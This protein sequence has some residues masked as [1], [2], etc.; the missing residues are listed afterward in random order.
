LK[1]VL[2]PIAMAAFVSVS[3]AQSA[4]A[5]PL[6]HPFTFVGVAGDCGPTPGSPIVGADWVKNFGLE[7]KSGKGNNALLL[8]KNGPTSDCSSAG[9][10]ITGVKNKTLTELGFDV[11]NGGH[12]SA[13]SPR[14][15]LTTVKNGVETFH[16]VGGCAAGTHTADAPQQGWTRV[17]FGDGSNPSEYF[18][19]VEPGSKIVSLE[20]I[21]DE[22]TDAGPD[23]SGF[24]MLDNIDV[25][26][27]LVTRP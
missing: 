13:G 22:G 23:F 9:A 6:A 14:F 12:C 7:D 19:P 10:T 11:R 8:S 25:N 27:T 18:P 20:V 5:A 16:F 17:R 26:G 21:A 15:N 3:L 2:V 1:S 24:V 4:S